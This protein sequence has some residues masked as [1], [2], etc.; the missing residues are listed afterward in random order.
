MSGIEIGTDVAARFELALGRNAEA[1]DKNT[2]AASLAYRTATP[3][4]IR[5]IFS[6]TVPASGLT[7]LASQQDSGPD[8]GFIWHVRSI[9]ISGIDPSAA[10]AGSA[11]VY[12]SA[13]DPRTTS[14]ATIGSLNVG[15][16]RDFTTSLPYKQFYGRGELPLRLNEELFIAVAGATAGTQIM[17][18]VQAENFMEGAGESGYGGSGGLR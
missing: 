7:F 5:L 18:A 4:P 15:D 10:T 17:A 14:L 16:L 13:A 3:A 12:V 9:I 2:K 11:F 6:A 1:L 8:M